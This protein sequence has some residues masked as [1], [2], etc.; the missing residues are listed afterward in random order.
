MIVSHALFDFFPELVYLHAFIFEYVVVSFLPYFPI[1]KLGKIFQA[2][3]RMGLEKAMGL[4]C[5]IVSIRLA[6]LRYEVLKVMAP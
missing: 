2:R 6:Q 1:K 4:Q 3:F 5:S